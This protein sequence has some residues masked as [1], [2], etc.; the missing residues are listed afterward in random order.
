MKI[1]INDKIRNIEVSEPK[2][3]AKILVRVLKAESKND[4][5]KEHMWGIYLTARNNIKKI[6][7]VSLGSLNTSIVHPREIYAPAIADG[8]ASIIIAHNHPSGNE[9][10]SKTD[11]ITTAKLKKAGDILGIEML[12][13]LIITER[14][15]YY[16]FNEHHKI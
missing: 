10:P 2:H 14:G 6:E 9:E 1:E 4:R 8:I 11:E 7:L 5:N 15:K 16:S 3:I 13:H 12:D